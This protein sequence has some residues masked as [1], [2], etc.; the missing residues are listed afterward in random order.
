MPQCNRPHIVGN[1]WKNDC[2]CLFLYLFDIEIG[3]CN[4]RFIS[5][6][7]RTRAKDIFR[8]LIQ[9]NVFNL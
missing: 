6:N 9:Y 8:T 2:K 1:I 7:I 3:Y 5:Q 4:L